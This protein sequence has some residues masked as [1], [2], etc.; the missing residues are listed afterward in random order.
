MRQIVNAARK[1]LELALTL[2]AQGSLALGTFTKL[3][4]RRFPKSRHVVLVEAEP[5]LQI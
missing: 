1:T 4:T 2:F 5:F 3:A